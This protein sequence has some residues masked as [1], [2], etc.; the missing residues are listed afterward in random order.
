MFF[1][2]ALEYGLDP[3]Y[4]GWGGEASPGFGASATA[5]RAHYEWIVPVGVDLKH[6]LLGYES[7]TDFVAVRGD[8]RREEDLQRAGLQATEQC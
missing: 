1:Q 7:N 3:A 4:A 2:R 8:A 6:R 5:T